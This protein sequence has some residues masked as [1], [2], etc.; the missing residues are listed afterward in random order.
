MANK[1]LYFEDIEVGYKFESP[2]GRTFTNAEVVNFAQFTGDYNLV[3]LDHEFAKTSLY[4]ENLVH[5]ACVLAV[6]GGMFRRTQFCADT[7]TTMLEMTGMKHV[8]YMNPV[9][10]NDTIHLEVEVLEKID[11]AE[12]TGTIVLGFNGVNQ[13]GEIALDNV[14][15]Y[16]FA[17]RNYQAGE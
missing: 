14:R 10:F 12:D 5:G 11:D 16:K 7:D 17:K 6:V 2:G 9:K 1:V 4:K 3:H 13:R 8:K 15:E